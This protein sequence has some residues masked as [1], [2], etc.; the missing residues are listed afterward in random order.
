MR[1]PFRW[2]RK[3]KQPQQPQPQARPAAAAP[4]PLGH[5]RMA[6]TKRS[7][8]SHK[9][10]AVHG[11]DVIEYTEG[12]RRAVLLDEYTAEVLGTWQELT[13]LHATALQKVASSRPASM[14]FGEVVPSG[15]GSPRLRRSTSAP[16]PPRRLGVDG[17]AGEVIGLSPIG[18]GGH[19]VRDARSGTWSASS[20]PQGEGLRP[21]RKVRGRTPNDPR[22]QTLLGEGIPPEDLVAALCSIVPSPGSAMVSSSTSVQRQA[23][24]LAHCLLSVWR[25][26]GRLSRSLL[27]FVLPQQLHGGDPDSPLAIF[28][29]VR[30]PSPLT[31]CIDPVFI[32]SDMLIHTDDPGRLGGMSFVHSLPPCSADVRSERGLPSPPLQPGDVTTLVSLSADSQKTSDAQSTRDS[33]LQRPS[34]VPRTSVREALNRRSPGKASSASVSPR[35]ASADG[36]SPLS[37]SRRTGSRFAPAIPEP[38]LATATPSEMTLSLPSQNERKPPVPPSPPPS[39]PTRTEAS[40]P[41]LGA[42]NGS[43]DISA[44]D[45]PTR[46]GEGCASHCG[47][48]NSNSNPV[49][50]ASSPLPLDS[51]EVSLSHCSQPPPRSQPAIG[52]G[53]A[54]QREGIFGSRAAAVEVP[55]TQT[56]SFALTLD[57]ARTLGADSTCLSDDDITARSRAAPVALSSSASMEPHGLLSPPQRRARMVL[58]QKTAVDGVEQPW[59]GDGKD[60]WLCVEPDGGRVWAGEADK[61]PWSLVAGPARDHYYVQNSAGLYL[62]VGDASSSVKRDANSVFVFC[63]TRFDASSVWQVEHVDLGSTISNV[64]WDG[65]RR[66]LSVHHYG[67]RDLRGD[68]SMWVVA[69]EWRNETSMWMLKDFDDSAQSESTPSRPRS[70]VEATLPPTDASERGRSHGSLTHSVSGSAAAVSPQAMS[71]GAV[72]PAQSSPLAPPRSGLSDSNPLTPLDVQ[73][74]SQTHQPP[75]SSEE[76]PQEPT[77]AAPAADLEI[78]SAVPAC[79]SPRDDGGSPPPH[80]HPIPAGAAPISRVESRPIGHTYSVQSVVTAAPRR[81]S[82]PLSPD[83]LLQLASGAM[84]IDSVRSRADSDAIAKTVRARPTGQ[85][86]ERTVTRRASLTP[87]GG[88]QHR[89]TRHG[90]PPR[91][92]PQQP[93][94]VRVNSQSARVSL[95]LPLGGVR[96]KDR[97]EPG[98]FRRSQTHRASTSTRAPPVRQHVSST[99]PQRPTPVRAFP[100]PHTH[101]TSSTSPTRRPPPQQRVR[102]SSPTRPVPR[103]MRAVSSQHHQPPASQ[104]PTQQHR[105]AGGARDLL[106]RTTSQQALQARYGAPGPQL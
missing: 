20:T 29:R 92:P 14:R 78:G 90:S 52:G 73:R 54:P 99:S 77:L 5:P 68:A 95:R 12:L 58:L 94:H 60:R 47:S 13:R 97:E 70:P 91:P 48:T 27:A 4:P 96:Q 100:T 16:Q 49:S 72:L 39:P 69:H 21:G 81:G 24:V 6:A 86:A 98:A 44:T 36:V 8:S 9:S 65:K 38:W 80:T 75:F 83:E 56:Q 33:P 102:G 74:R 19:A 34:P 35:T 85:P 76:A 25:L 55:A 61:M 10:A 7:N 46:V 45:S 43:M 3:G 62:T 31:P 50:A 103:S 82:A 57:T 41:Q 64:G 42:S 30:C 104:P 32:A 93:A 40:P 51:S 105:A 59:K 17:C 22:F 106:S 23:V 101:H 28:T 26:S 71:R 37:M 53:W 79:Y 2:M 87:A 63:S 18:V 89:S 11:A 88:A 84:R 67:E 66:Y 1:N 15:S